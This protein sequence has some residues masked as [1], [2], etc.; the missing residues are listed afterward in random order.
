MTP[1]GEDSSAPQRP[2]TEDVGEPAR[3]RTTNPWW[4]WSDGNKVRKT[5][6]TSG[7]DGEEEEGEDT[8]A[9]PTYALQRKLKPSVLVRISHS[10]HLY[11]RVCFKY[12][13]VDI[14]PSIKLQ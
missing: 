13:T 12:T 11:V 6:T 9:G 14:Y 3:E 1:P 2:P 4:T 5:S 8:E 10:R 7:S